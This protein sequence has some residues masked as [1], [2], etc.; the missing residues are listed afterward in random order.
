MP[1]VTV[2]I[3]EAEKKKIDEL[4]NFYKKKKWSKSKVFYEGLQALYKE[5]KKEQI[6]LQAKKMRSEYLNNPELNVFADL[7]GEDFYE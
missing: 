7:D 4:L 5:F 3:P 1:R 2:F 6:R